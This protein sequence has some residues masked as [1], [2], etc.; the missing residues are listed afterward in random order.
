MD[1][2]KCT[3][4]LAKREIKKIIKKNFD[5]AFALDHEF[6]YDIE[7]KLCSKAVRIL[8]SILLY[9]PTSTRSSLHSVRS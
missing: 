1:G 6:H 7:T 5:A 4:R 2:G 8:M 3:F 9:V